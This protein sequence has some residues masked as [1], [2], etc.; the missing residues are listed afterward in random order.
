MLAVCTLPDITWDIKSL[1]SS[2]AFVEAYG[3]SSGN[4][5]AIHDERD[6]SFFRRRFSDKNRLVTNRPAEG[7]IRRKTAY[8]A[9]SRKPVSVHR[10]GVVAHRIGRTHVT[11]DVKASLIPHHPYGCSVVSVIWRFTCRLEHRGGPLAEL[12][13]NLDG[14]RCATDGDLMHFWLVERHSANRMLIR[15]P[16]RH[17]HDH[18]RRYATG[19]KTQ[20]KRK[21][22]TGATEGTPETF[23]E[24]AFRNAEPPFHS[25]YRT[26]QHLCDLVKRHIHHVVHNDRLPELGRKPFYRSAN[27]VVVGIPENGIVCL[28]SDKTHVCRKHIRVNGNGIPVD[29][30]ADV[31]GAYVAE[32][33]EKP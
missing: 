16:A 25:T 14:F 1:M 13:V 24:D 10:L 27:G 7:G 33:A 9:T 15:V 23:G 5:V 20:C 30:A 8:H 12:A 4:A 6:N 2:Y 22:C 31:L 17:P 11:R 28:V 32:N 21:P 18:N 19:K 3:L 26:L 29:H